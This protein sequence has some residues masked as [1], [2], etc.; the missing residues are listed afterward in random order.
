M[1]YAYPYVLTHMRAAII[2][3]SVMDRLQKLFDE[4]KNTLKLSTVD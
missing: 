2:W 4:S 3:A 1:D